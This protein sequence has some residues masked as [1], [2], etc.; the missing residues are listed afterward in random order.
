M[1]I[2]GTKVDNKVTIAGIKEDTKMTIAGIKEDT[3]NDDRRNQG[4]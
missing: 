3:K 2:A 4:G 1:M